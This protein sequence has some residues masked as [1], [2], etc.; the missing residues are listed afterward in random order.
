MDKNSHNRRIQHTPARASR[1]SLKTPR[2]PSRSCTLAACPVA[3]P[4]VAAD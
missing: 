4:Q 3:R 2:R 1:S